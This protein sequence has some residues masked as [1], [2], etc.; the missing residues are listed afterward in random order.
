MRHG[1]GEHATR[2]AGC[3][4]HA[5]GSGGS[6][7]SSDSATKPGT[8]PRRR[9]P[10]PGAPPP[11]EHD[12][13][14]HGASRR[15]AGPGHPPS[16]SGSADRGVRPARPAAPGPPDNLDVTIEGDGTVVLVETDVAAKELP[17]EVR[18]SVERVS[19]GNYVMIRAVERFDFSRGN[20]FSTYATWAIRNQFARAV[21]GKGRPR[22]LFLL[23]HEAIEA[24][25]D[26]GTDN[27]ERSDLQERRQEA[28][29]RL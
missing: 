8:R 12:R 26:P 6:P 16:L 27:L 5:T 24:A 17:K 15:E 10:L 11:H 25:V 19:D 22:P 21:R 18:R 20:K 1:R 9:R 13:Q 3:G 4:T 2:P 7:A 23:D 28:F 29:A 14:D